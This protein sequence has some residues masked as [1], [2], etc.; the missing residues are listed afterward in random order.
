LP[1]RV[2]LPRYMWQLDLV[3]FRLPVT[4]YHFLARFGRTLWSTY[5]SRVSVWLLW[6]TEPK[7]DPNAEARFL[8]LGVVQY[9]RAGRQDQLHST[10]RSLLAA[11]AVRAGIFSSMP[12]K[13]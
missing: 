5:L 10:L 12:E 8:Q 11:L 7:P 4:V 1:L 2:I 9:W 6:F 13:A 3:V